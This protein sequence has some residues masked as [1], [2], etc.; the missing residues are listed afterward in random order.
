MNLHLKHLE[1]TLRLLR[2]ATL[3][4][5]MCVTWHKQR[6]AVSHTFIGN[7]KYFLNF[8]DAKF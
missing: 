8:K 2:V 1:V 4:N 6:Y 5:G 7:Y 3:V